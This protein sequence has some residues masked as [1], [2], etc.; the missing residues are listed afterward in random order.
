MIEFALEKAEEG[1]YWERLLKD[2]SKQHWLKVDFNKWKDEDDSEDEGG[3]GGA[4]LEE[5]KIVSSSPSSSSFNHLFDGWDQRCLKTDD[6]ELKLRWDTTP[7]WK[8]CDRAVREWIRW[9]NWPGRTKPR[10]T[11]LRN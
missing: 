1:P 10:K 3:A 2:K 11:S 9:R 4:D 7:S 5:V 6:F 8:A